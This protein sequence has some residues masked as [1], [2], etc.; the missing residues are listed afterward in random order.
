ML[1]LTSPMRPYNFDA[2]RADEGVRNDL[3][4]GIRLGWTLPIYRR[5]DDAFY[6]R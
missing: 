3:L 1:G 5:S 4:H 2:Q 6:I